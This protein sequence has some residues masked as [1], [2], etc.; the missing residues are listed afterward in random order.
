MLQVQFT[1]LQNKAYPGH[2]LVLMDIRRNVFL[3]ASPSF[4]HQSICDD[5]DCIG[6][7]IDQN[8]NFV[9]L[10]ANASG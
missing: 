5:V 3:L 10:S 4:T 8:D 6:F 2:Q 7:S 9:P 1:R